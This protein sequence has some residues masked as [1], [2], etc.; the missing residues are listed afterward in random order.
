VFDALSDR[1]RDVLG[2]LTGRGHVTEA[3]VDAALREVR[4]A[5][6]E[7][8][9][10]Y[11]V[12]KDF[13][14][15]VRE[16]AVGA[17]IL[18][19]LNAGQQVIKI[20]HEELTAL[21]GQGDRTFRLTGQP[22]VVA[23]VGLQGSG[24]TT[25][26]AKLGRYLVRQGRQPLLVA[27]DPYRPAAVEQLVQLGR[28]LAI[29]VH[30]AA[31]GT[32]VVEIAREGVA[33]A[34]RTG[35]DVVIL[36]TAGRL[37]V[38]EALMEE[39]REVAAAVRPSETLL[40]VDA[41]TG[42]E[43]VH[44]AQAF[45]EAVPLT[46]LVLTKIDGDARGGA[47]LSIGAVSGLAVKF[48]GTGEKTDA[49]EPFYPDRLAGRILGMG[50]V[51]TLIERAQETFDAKAAEKAAE[52]LRKNAF[53]LDDFL[54]QMQQMKRMGPIGQLLEMIP[55]MRGLA[56][57]AQGAADRGELKHVEAIIQS[58]THEERADPSIL[59]ASRRRRI[60][61][62][63]GTTLP[64]VNRLVKQFGE[65]QKLMRTLQRQGGRRP[66]LPFGR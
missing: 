22:A 2:R 4:L 46:G 12:V 44:V 48:L 62:G 18:E 21:L 26:A 61:H 40:V 39:I 16:R 29:P 23:L 25:S 33:Q 60:A 51:L 45:G 37:T 49:L 15:R 65:M 57:E 7:A 64:D 3:D 13:V 52:K 42:Q 53:T 9:V 34:K 56:K 66:P 27:A 30:A 47:A 17:D 36:D 5:L 38:D 59:N 41:M 14:A 63:S 11:R 8:D 19:S 1:L 58:M 20:V 32:P 55:G 10:N 24:K 28:S 31:P 6:L 50:D 54:E 43:A 35:R